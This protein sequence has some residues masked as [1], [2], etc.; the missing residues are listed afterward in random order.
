MLAAYL[1]AQR[2]VAALCGRRLLAVGT[3]FAAARGELHVGALDWGLALPV[4]TT[5]AFT[6]Q[7]SVSLALPLFVVT[8]ASQNLP[9]VAVIRAAGYDCRSRGSSRCTGVATLLLAPFGAFALTSRRSPR[10]SA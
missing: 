5:P 7:A 6:W 3:A 4:F 1:L 9:G 2:A 8:M 10:R